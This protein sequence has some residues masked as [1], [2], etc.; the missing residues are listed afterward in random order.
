MQAAGLPFIDLNATNSILQFFI[1]NNKQPVVNRINIIDSE[2]IFKAGC[3]H[4]I[5]SNQNVKFQH[6]RA[7]QAV[8]QVNI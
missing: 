1:S 6:L 2:L 4:M 8:Y 5:M 7:I 3:A